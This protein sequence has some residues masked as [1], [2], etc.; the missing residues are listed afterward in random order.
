ML[1]ICFNHVVLDPYACQPH[2]A[3]C[4]IYRS[5]FS[6]LVLVLQF[7]ADNLSLFSLKAI[8]LS[9][10]KRALFGNA[11]C[12]LPKDEADLK[13]VGEPIVGSLTFQH[14]ILLISIGCAGASAVMSLWLILKHLHRY[15]QP[16]QQR[17]IIR[18]IFTPVVFAVLS[19]LAIL[20]YDAAI[21]LIP[22]RDLYETFALASLFLLFTAYVAPDED[23]RESFFST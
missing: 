20:N 5:I 16:M 21:Y 3:L 12:P 1:S 19:A 17:Q 7:Q 13:L 14:I 2:V 15:T 6:C 4:Y 10:E 23:T 22:L 8:S 18:I 11:T 9:M